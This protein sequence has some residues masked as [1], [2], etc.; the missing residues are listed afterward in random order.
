M[1]STAGLCPAAQ[2]RTSGPTYIVPKWERLAFHL[3][4][5]LTL[6]KSEGVVEGQPRQ[7]LLGRGN[8]DQN[9]GWASPPSY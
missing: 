8:K 1:N 9:Q 6:D 7:P 5:G 3:L 4:R 2:T